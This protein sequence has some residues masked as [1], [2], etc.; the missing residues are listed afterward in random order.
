MNSIYYMIYLN[1]SSKARKAN[2]QGIMFRS[3][4]A[5][6]LRA[7]ELVTKPGI[8]GAEVEALGLTSAGVKE[9]TKLGLIK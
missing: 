1:G 6:I 2:N 4:R 7:Q 5:A 9:F 8:T 3:R